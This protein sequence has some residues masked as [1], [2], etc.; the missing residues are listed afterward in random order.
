MSTKLDVPAT[1][2]E[3]YGGAW[4]HL[5]EMVR[6]IWLPGLLYL[7]L[8]TASAFLDPETQFFPVLVLE[9]AGLFLWAV[10]AVAWHRFILIGDAPSGAFHLT[11]GRRE[12]RFLLLSVFLF[13]LLMPG[14]AIAIAAERMTGTMT[15]SLLS[16]L[17]LL[18]FLVAVYFFVRL[19]LLLPA[20]SIDDPVDP[21]LVLERTR[22]NFWR[23]VAVFVSVVVPVVLLA[24]LLG[25]LLGGGALLQILS[26]AAFA[27]VSVFFA[28]VNVAVLS[29]A[30]R[31]LVGPPGSVPS[32]VH[33]DPS[34]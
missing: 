24:V 13:L 30:Y 6:L 9:L 31:E 4:N 22:G 17:G 8:S 34:F 2:R 20:V 3:S 5:G 1:I 15:G 28:V 7:V 14:I 26:I 12:A 25:S 19:S 27:L 29:I 11:F 10:I 33:I 23:L 32:P 18:L 21:R 16:F